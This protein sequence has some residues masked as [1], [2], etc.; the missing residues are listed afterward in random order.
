MH[1]SIHL[2]APLLALLPA[3]TAVE[4]PRDAAPIEQGEQ[5]VSIRLVVTSDAISRPASAQVLPLRSAGNPTAFDLP[6]QVSIEQRVTIRVSPRPAPMAPMMF[7]NDAGA[8]GSARYIE[9]KFGKCLPMGG[10]A[11]VQPVSGRKLMLIMRDNRIFTAE[12][13]KG[14]Q[15]RDFYSGFLVAKS[16][17]GMICKGRDKL[18]AR[19]GT[20]CEVDGFRQI[21]ELG[22]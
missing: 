6:E 8:G 1:P 13:E 17:D 21:V 11:G 4:V 3:A 7:Q 14:C 10:I 15:A 16:S 2:F 9:R 18:R 12:L 5:S 19:S 20:T 22:V